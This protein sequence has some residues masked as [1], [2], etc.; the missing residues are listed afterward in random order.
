M[1]KTPLFPP[2]QQRGATL[3]IALILLMVMSLMAAATLRSTNIQ[4]HM[5]AN[6]YDRNL[7]FQSAEAGLK[8]GERAV[9]N[10]IQGGASALPACN[11]PS[12]DGLYDST[13]PTNCATPL[14]EGPAPGAS[15]TYW[16]DPLNDSDAERIQFPNLG[17][18][19]SPYYIVELLTDKAPCE[20]DNPAGGTTGSTASAR[21]CR[22][23]RI[24]AIS[25]TGNDD[26]RARVILQSIYATE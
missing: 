5:S 26:G 20:I 14:W 1:K 10:W 19:L 18:S 17:L 22:R 7:A 6:V 12:A 13:T 3:I 4:E 11:T 25:R 16:H 9:E 2:S 15:G 21:S 23:F 24:T 8:M